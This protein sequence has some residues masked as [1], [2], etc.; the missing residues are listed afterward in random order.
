[1][2]ALVP[3]LFAAVLAA[4]DIGPQ[5]I[6]PGG[7]ERPVHDCAQAVAGMA[8]DQRV[9]EAFRAR[10][11]DVLSLTWEDTGRW[12]GS[13]VGPNISDLTIQ[14]LGR[15]A[16]HHGWC[17]PVV[18]YPNFA[19]TTCD[20]PIDRLKLLVGNER[21]SALRAIDLRTYLRDFAAHQHAPTGFLTG[22]LVGDRDDVVLASAQ[23]CFLP[24]E[25]GATTTFAPVLFNYQSTAGSPAVLTIVATPEGTSAQVITNDGVAASGVWRGQRLFHNRAGRRAPLTA[26]RFSDHR[27][28]QDADGTPVAQDAATRDG[29]SLVLVIQVPLVVPEPPIRALEG[30][31]PAAADLKCEMAA[32][33]GGRAGVETAVIASGPTEGP[34]LGLAGCTIQRDF[35][36]PIR[37]TV[38]FYQAT[39]QATVGDADVQRVAAAI[40][41]IYLDA[42]AVGSLVVDGASGRATE[43]Q[44]VPAPW[45]QPWWR[46]PCETYAARHGEPWQDAVARVRARLGADWQPADAREL[47]NALELARR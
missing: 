13:S 47:A 23:A 45:P 39:D 5:A 36:F 1:M 26:Q 4:Q 35:R 41:R 34:W 8:G 37:A 2:R 32:V 30:A 19:D 7:C 43:H 44:V 14:V 10:G 28:R 22:A 31:C 6:A 27:A 9:A 21:G 18:R 29:L 20:V 40:E 11:L 25:P 24:V 42:D 46:T 15:P 3:T 38:Q 33:A 17:M 16:A 12:K